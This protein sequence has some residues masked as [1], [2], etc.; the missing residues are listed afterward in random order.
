L[1]GL[2]SNTNLNILRLLEETNVNPILLKNLQT[3]LEFSK[4]KK[5]RTFVNCWHISEFES[6]AMWKLYSSDDMG[7]LIKTSFKR[8]K[9]SFFQCQHAVYIVIVKYIDWDEEAIPPE[10]ALASFSSKRKSFVYEREIRAL[11]GILH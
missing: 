1:E 11:V 8:L 5:E 10:N 2:Y 9:N 4:D 6:V 3:M 7:V